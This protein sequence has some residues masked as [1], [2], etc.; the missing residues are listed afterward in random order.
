M[1]GENIENIN[2]SERSFAATFVDNHLLM[3]TV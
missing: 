1:S 2:R 3:N